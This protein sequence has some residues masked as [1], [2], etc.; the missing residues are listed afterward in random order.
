MQNPSPHRDI[1]IHKN[2]FGFVIQSKD[3]TVKIKDRPTNRRK[4]FLI[5]PASVILIITSGLALWINLTSIMWTPCWGLLE[6][7]PSSR[8]FDCVTNG[9]SPMP[10]RFEG[11]VYIRFDM[12]P[13]DLD[14]VLSQEG[15]MFH[16]ATSPSTE[17]WNEFPRSLFNYLFACDFENVE[18]YEAYPEFCLLCDP[19]VLMRIDTS[20]SDYYRVYFANVTFKAQNAF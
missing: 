8:N 5:I 7:P 19:R 2:P 4:W 16:V 3:S 20:H 1:M 10:M 13:E 17:L 11:D 18:S 6:L 14:F 9:S 12:S 15:L